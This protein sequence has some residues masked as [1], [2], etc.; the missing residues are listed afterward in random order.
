MILKLLLCEEHPSLLCVV[1]LCFVVVFNDQIPTKN[2]N[3]TPKNKNKRVAVQ[4]GHNLGSPCCGN[5]LWGKWGEQA[6][7]FSWKRG[8]FPPQTSPIL[9][10]TGLLTAFGFSL[11]GWL[12]TW[13]IFLL[14]ITGETACAV[15]TADRR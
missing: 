3:K 10:L 5:T 14:R 6:L 8:L 1:G 7:V 2:K 9:E 13:E 11:D 15:V 12:F 4:P